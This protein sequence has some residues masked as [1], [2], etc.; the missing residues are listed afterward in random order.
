MP[1]YTV[2]PGEL[3]KHHAIIDKIKTAL[4]AQ[5]F[6]LIFIFPTLSLLKEVQEELL[7]ESDLNG[8]GGV[9]LLLFEGFIEELVRRFGLDGRRPSPIEQELLIT[10]AFFRL[11]QAGKLGY[12]NQAP[13]SPSYRRAMLEGIREWKRAGLTL[14]IFKEWAEGQSAKEQ[15]LALVY[16]AYQELLVE[17]GLNEEDLILNQLE[18]LRSE[19]GKIPE[20]TNVVMYGFTDLTPLQND[21]LKILEFWF[22]F[23]FIID[24]TNVPKLQ[25]MVSRHFP[26]KFPQPDVI[27]SKNAL[28]GLQAGFGAKQ[29]SLINLEPEDLSVQLIEAAGLEREITGIAR[30]IARLITENPGCQWDDFLIITPNLQ[31]FVKIAGP[32]F[33]QYRLKIDEGPTRTAREYPAVSVLYEALTAIDTDWQ[34]P[35]MELLIRHFYTGPASSWGDRL[36]LWIGEH[37]GGVSSRRRWL[38]LI[39]DSRFILSATQ[40]GYDLTPLKQ[41]VDWLNKIPKQS[42][43]KDY[44]DLARKWFE[45]HVVLDVESLPGTPSQL[46]LELGG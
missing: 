7:R 17:R 18:K 5:D 2:I 1:K 43:L 21:F 6:T 9:R 27:P 35:E 10:E 4:F 33:L 34:W 15:Q 22:D 3:K 19:A 20:T 25:Q 46:A 14:E 40:V 30:E 42:Y 32:I 8:F 39:E 26:V 11:N 29:P 28:E 45:T 12:L 13:F 41:M 37:Y 23:E 44:L 38:D 31:E 16:K 24:P 36:L